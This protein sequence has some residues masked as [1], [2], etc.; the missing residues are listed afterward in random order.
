[1]LPNSG[2]WWVNQG[3]GY[4]RE[5]PGGYLFAHKKDRRGAVLVSHDLRRLRVGDI[6]LHYTGG[7]I[8]AIGRVASPAVE[9]EVPGGQHAGPEGDVAYQVSV[10]YHD[11]SEPIVLSSIP[12]AWRTP[13]AGPFD[14]DGKVKMPYLMPVSPNF[15]EKM[16]QRW[17]REL[18]AFISRTPNI[19]LFQ[20][21][22]AHY[23][24][25]DP[26][27]YLLKERVREVSVGHEDEWRVTRYRAQMR[28][29]DKVILWQGGQGKSAHDAGIYGFGELSS[30]S[31]HTA[32]DD[33][34]DDASEHIVPDGP[35]VRFLYTHLFP[36]PILRSRLREHP[37]L[38]HMQV[39]QAPQ[40]TNFRV[41]QEE[42][43]ALLQIISHPKLKPFDS[44]VQ[45]LVDQ[46]YVFPP[47][48]ISNYLLALQTKR[49]VILTGISGTGKTQIA[50]AT[51]RAMQPSVAVPVIA[52]ETADVFNLKVY[53]YMLKYHQMVL[54][55]AL[56]ADLGLPML[57]T[58]DNDKQ[59]DVVFPDG[60]V[61]LAFV[62]DP[63][64]NVTH[65]VFRGEFRAWFDTQFKAGDRFQLK[66]IERPDGRYGLHFSLPNVETR[67]ERLANYLLIAVRPDWTD[68]RGLLG[69]YN[70]LIGTYAVPPFYACYWTLMP[71]CNEPRRRNDL[72]IHIS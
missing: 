25:G 5:R 65:L 39:L 14:R 31:E 13:D 34:T 43:D 10:N 8:Q 24:Q 6:T 17:P 49:F 38:H 45:S 22:P 16:A 52:Q 54:P 27:A 53:P 66:P 71:K 2:F 3:E 48:L 55:S 40:G 12:L 37:V 51:A 47:E 50:L 72:H 60:Q 56:V 59:I 21:N 57:P 28:P 26:N 68:N 67:T 1:L 30:V 63:G 11:L 20:A 41:T 70:P 69:Y 32:D 4:V 18:S 19:W 42:W 15:V 64:R 44:L 58:S 33:V 7:M 23:A 62:K 35:T 9:S 36:E 29:G 46:G 61:S